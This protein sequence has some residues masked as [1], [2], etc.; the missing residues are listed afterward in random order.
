MSTDD[1]LASQTVLYDFEG[2]SLLGA[3][4]EFLA[5]RKERILMAGSAKTSLPGV[6][7]IF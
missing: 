3:L 7:Y 6:K 4:M 5:L 2:N 1:K